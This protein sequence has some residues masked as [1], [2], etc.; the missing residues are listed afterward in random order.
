MKLFISADSPIG[1]ALIGARVGDI[2]EVNTPGG[3]I[4]LEVRAIRL[5]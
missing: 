1:A 5:R 3:V 2:V 4:K